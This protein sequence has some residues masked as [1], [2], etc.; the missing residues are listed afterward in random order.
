MA[1]IKVEED[2]WRIVIESCR[3]L[4][5]LGETHTEAGMRNRL[6]TM[7]LLRSVQEA[8]MKPPQ[9]ISE[10]E[11]DEIRKERWG[12]SKSRMANRRLA[13]ISEDNLIPDAN[14]STTKNA[15]CDEGSAKVEVCVSVDASNSKDVDEIVLVEDGEEISASPSLQPT[16]STSA[17]TTQENNNRNTSH[18][19]TRQQLNPSSSS[20]ATVTTSSAAGSTAENIFTAP[21]IAPNSTL[22]FL[23]L[24]E[25]EV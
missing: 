4:Y 24:I 22:Y 20:S 18:T 25:C 3:K 10:K 21:K 6:M 1:R 5:Y 7:R 8:T 17:S 14:K 9:P 16:P 11:K 23:S 19:S 15:L 12:K 2:P 13:I